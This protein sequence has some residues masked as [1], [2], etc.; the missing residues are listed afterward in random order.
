[1][2]REIKFRAFITRTGGLF[3]CDDFFNGLGGK[4]FIINNKEWS[5]ADEEGEICC[6]DDAILM[7]YTGLKD[8]ENKEI[9]EGDIVNISTIYNKVEIEHICKVVFESGAFILA[10]DTITDSYMTFI[11]ANGDWDKEIIG[12]IY[13]NPELLKGE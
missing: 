12:N 6:Q 13:K 10:A 7:Q 1:M 3:Y 8:K 11:E 4:N 2:T 5:L 9:Y